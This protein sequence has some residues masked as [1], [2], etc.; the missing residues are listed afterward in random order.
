[1]AV[2]AL[3]LHV[4][5]VHLLSS[6][7]LPQIPLPCRVVGIYVWLWR[8]PVQ[9]LSLGGGGRAP[10]LSRVRGP[11]QVLSDSGGP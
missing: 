10:A 7:V 1:M 11:W 6:L 2:V 3:W 9:S 4:W 5:N 8:G